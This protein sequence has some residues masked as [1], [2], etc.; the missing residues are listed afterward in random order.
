V[1]IVWR[2]A[3][4]H[5]PLVIMWIALMKTIGRAPLKDTRTSYLASG[6]ENKDAFS[7]PH[8]QNKGID[9]SDNS[10]K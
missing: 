5:V 1:I 8:D 2:I 6:K 9:K 7:A 10:V 4:Y 3:S